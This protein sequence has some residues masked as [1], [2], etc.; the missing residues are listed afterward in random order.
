[1]M[2]NA[3]EKPIAGSVTQLKMKA[4]KKPTKSST[5][6]RT[7]IAVTIAKGISFKI[8]K[9]V[10]CVCSFIILYYYYHPLICI[11]IF[12]HSRMIITQIAIVNT[13]NSAIFHLFC[14]IANTLTT[15]ATH[16][17]FNIKLDISFIF[18]LLQN[19]DLY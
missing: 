14:A 8:P 4:I 11:L 6:N 16:Q 3:I 2:K 15:G 9:M 18:L 7:I 19:F 17:Y 1:M 10:V 5:Q 13:N 12:T